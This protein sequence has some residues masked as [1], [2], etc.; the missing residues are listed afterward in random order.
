MTLSVIV[1]SGMAG[2]METLCGQAFGAG[3]FEKLGIY[4]YTAV[5]SPAMVCVPITVVWIFLDK[6]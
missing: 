3:Q 4:T 6:S 5:I 2:G 1:Q